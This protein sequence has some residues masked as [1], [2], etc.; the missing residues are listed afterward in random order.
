M[1]YCFLFGW[2]PLKHVIKYANIYYKMNSAVLHT[3]FIWWKRSSIYVYVRIN[4]DCSDTQTTW[5]Q[6]GANA[7]CN[8]PFANAWDDSTSYKDVLHWK[9]IKSSTQILSWK[10]KMIKRYIWLMQIHPME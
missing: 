6:Y 3:M 8:D 9:K 2:L 5:F 7:A 4:F 1:Y 10:S